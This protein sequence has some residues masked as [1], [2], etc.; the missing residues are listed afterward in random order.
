MCVCSCVSRGRGVEYVGF[1][2]VDSCSFGM[3]AG[4]GWAVGAYGAGRVERWAGAGMCGCVGVAYMCVCV[5]VHEYGVCM[6]QVAYVRVSS[7][8]MCVR[9]GRV[10]RGG[11]WGG[12]HVCA[13]VVY[14]WVGFVC[15][16]VPCAYGCVRTYV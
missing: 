2:G 11:W 3:E 6:C 4:G 12:I 15:T 14:A 16:W 13:Y 5:C 10:E 9:D 8:H 7:T 1:C